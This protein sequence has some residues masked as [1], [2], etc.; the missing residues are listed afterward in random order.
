MKTLS[1]LFFLVMLTVNIFGQNIKYSI[2]AGSNYS[3]FSKFNKNSFIEPE[4]TEYGYSS[5]PS[6]LI[7]E[8]IRSKGGFGFFVDNDFAFPINSRLAFKTGF[9][10]RMNN[11]DI[12]NNS[13][14]VDSAFLIN[15]DWN[16]VGTIVYPSISTKNN[17]NIITI[18]FP[19]EMQVNFIKGKLLMSSGIIISRLI[20]SRK[21]SYTGIG[22]THKYNADN[23][24][25][26][27]FFNVNL[28][29]EYKVFKNFFAGISYDLS[30]SEIIKYSNNTINYNKLHINNFSLSLSY[31]L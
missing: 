17:Y 4:L 29:I 30:V 2:S 3:F 27:I 9:G 15:P 28:G 5:W 14:N 1:T 8:S 21:T 13:I 12:D 18:T 25:E 19:I 11:I 31:S 6:S 20:N 24:F 7:G 26:K 16:S 10:L 22:T 23:E